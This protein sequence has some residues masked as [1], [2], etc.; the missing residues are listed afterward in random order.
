MFLE[1]IEILS[2]FNTVSVVVRLMLALVIGALM[3]LEREK[4]QRPAGIRTYTLV[5]VGSALACIT[6]LYMSQMYPGTDPSRIPAQ[7]ISGIGF[8]GAGTIIVTKI[9]RIKGLT[10]AAGLW[11]CAAVGIAVG[12]GF[13]SGAILTGIIIIVSLRLLEAVDDHYARNR[14]YIMCYAEYSSKEFIKQLVCYTKKNGYQLSDLDISKD[15]DSS[16]FVTFQI[17]ISKP[18][19]RQEIIAQIQ[20]LSECML[21]EEIQ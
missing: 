1:N 5:C 12:A 8:L 11:C 2:E 9:H 19:K 13:Y 18:E 3:G 21:V 6:N 17:K 16:Y 7:I 15:N 4:K 20:E 14:E 10:T